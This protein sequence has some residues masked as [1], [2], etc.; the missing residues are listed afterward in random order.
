MTPEIKG[1]YDKLKASG[2]LE[3]L[4]NIDNRSFNYGQGKLN[5]VQDRIRYLV[6]IKIFDS[7]QGAWENQFMIDLAQ[8]NRK[9]AQRAYEEGADKHTAIIQSGMGELHKGDRNE[10]F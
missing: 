10:S 2:H 1:W 4:K 5:V 8:K 6:S 7:E 3:A 9:K